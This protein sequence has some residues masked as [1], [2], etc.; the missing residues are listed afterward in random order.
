MPCSPVFTI[1][2]RAPVLQGRGVRGTNPIHAGPVGAAP[3][4]PVT[5]RQVCLRR[6]LRAK[7]VHIRGSGAMFTPP[8]G[9]TEESSIPSH[10][11]AVQTA[12]STDF[13]PRRRLS[14]S[15]ALFGLGLALLF[16]SSPVLPIIMPGCV[17]SQAY[18]GQQE[19]TMAIYAGSR[20]GVGDCSSSSSSLDSATI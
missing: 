19:K 14:P 2:K 17:K 20:G 7:A 13:A 12:K 11:F 1:K 8:C 10:G 15:P 16:P 4:M 6:T 5:W 18:G 9:R 3:C